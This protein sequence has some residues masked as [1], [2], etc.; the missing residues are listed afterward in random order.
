MQWLLFK[1]TRVKVV[2]TIKC[3]A[4]TAQ[5]TFR[6][7]M[8][9]TLEPFL[10]WNTDPTELKASKCLALWFDFLLDTTSRVWEWPGTVAVFPGLKYTTSI[11]NN[12]GMTR[13]RDVQNPGVRRVRKICRA[14]GKKN[15]VSTTGLHCCSKAWPGTALLG[16]LPT[17]WCPLGDHDLWGASQALR[18]LQRST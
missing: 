2:V 12:A 3:R 11:H 8:S 18:R 7:V 5:N 10:W 15:H 4:L 16:R 1:N 14:L 17:A 9:T 6:P 13:S